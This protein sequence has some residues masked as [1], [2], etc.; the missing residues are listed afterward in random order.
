[1]LTVNIKC[2]NSDK[3]TVEIE[4]DQLTVLELKTVV[5]EKL[6][7]PVAQQRLILKGRVLKDD[8]Q[9]ESYG[10]KDGDTVH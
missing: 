7:I 2:S 3:A 5:N 9:L 6:S 4:S 10:L 8:N 1:M